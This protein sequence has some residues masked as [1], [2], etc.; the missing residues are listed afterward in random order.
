MRPSKREELIRSALVVFYREG[1]HSTGM[2]RVAAETGISKTAIY[3]HF[4]TKEDLILATLRLRDE[5]FRY[6]FFGR[7]EKL[8]PEPLGQLL[9]MFDVLGEWFSTED[10]SGCMFIKAASEFQSITHP[11]HQQSA[12]HKRLLERHIEK[13][14]KEAGITDAIG[15]ARQLLLL[16]EGAIVSAHLGHTT[17][18]ARDAK[19]AAD[20]L[21]KIYA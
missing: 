3:K 21:L 11:I 15:L 9:A 5:T 19:K 17:N 4:R 16:K 14:A 18:P 2:D 13:L 10:F 6:W 7:M 1:F 12:E 20:A 8:S